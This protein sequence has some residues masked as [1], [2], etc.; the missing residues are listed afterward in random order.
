MKDIVKSSL[1]RRFSNPSLKGVRYIAIDEIRIRKGHKYITIVL[2]LERGNVL[3]VGDG[4]G[5]AAIEPFWERVHR[6]KCHIE[7]VST[8]LGPA[9]IAAVL[10]KLPGV[11][12]FFDRF[13]VVKLMN[14]ALTEIRRGLY[15]EYKDSHFSLLLQLFP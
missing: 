11:P 15:N 2:D 12:L 9:Y 4:K 10:D 5:M 14:D 3:F 13:H 1:A 8:D 6:S 7:A